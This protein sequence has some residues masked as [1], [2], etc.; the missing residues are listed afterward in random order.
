MGP[1]CKTSAALGLA[2]ST[3]SAAVSRLCEAG[4]LQQSAG[5][6]RNKIFSYTAYLDLLRDGT[7]LS[8]R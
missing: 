3:V 2:F 4:I 7:E 1:F 5:A 6:Q 8:A